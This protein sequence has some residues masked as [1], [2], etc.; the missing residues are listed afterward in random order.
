MYNAFHCSPLEGFILSEI[1]NTCCA[2]AQKSPMLRAYHDVL[3]A[4]RTIPRSDV[5]FEILILETMQSGLS[6]ST[7]LAKK[8]NIEN[9]L[10]GFDAELM[11]TMT[12]DY[13]ENTLMNDEGIIRNR[14][15]LNGARQ[16]A[17]AWLELENPRD[18]L[19]SFI[20]GHKIIND[21]RYPE[22]VPS[23]TEQSIAMSKALKSKGFVHIGPK[24]AYAFMQAAGFVNDHT[25]NCHHHPFHP[26]HKR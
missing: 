23:E 3:W 14:S 22:L 25:T 9:A 10:F 26:D 21:W 5:L 17:K 18:F 20:G 11:S 6:W 13:I 12:D 1:D 24:V 16:N 19:L 15:K 7:V 2:W 4:P 8:E